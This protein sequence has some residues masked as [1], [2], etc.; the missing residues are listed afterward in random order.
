MTQ[1]KTKTVVV[2]PS[3]SLIARKAAGKMIVKTGLRA[4]AASR[5]DANKRG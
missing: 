5:E 2:R 3:T 1:I 4:G